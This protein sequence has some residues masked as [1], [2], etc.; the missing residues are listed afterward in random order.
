VNPEGPP[1]FVTVPEAR[2]SENRTESRFEVALSADGSATVRGTSRITGAQAPEYRRA[3]LSAHDRRSQLEKAF[4]RTFPG[5]R[6]ESV[7]LSDVTRIEEDVRMEFSLAVPRYAQADGSELR[8]NAFGAGSGYLETY[9]SLSERRHPLDLGE[10]TES[11]FEYRYSLPEGFTATE[12]PDDVSGEVPEVAFEVR[13][14]LDG[15][16][17]VVSGHVTFR[18]GRVAPERYPAFRALVARLDGAFT[19]RVR[20]APAHASLEAR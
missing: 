2:A 6:V 17:L 8:F 1:R 16:T 11:R 15:N 5:L 9:A 10:P 12:L 13:H 18:G 19:R 14:R 4:N 7:T 3:Y 20:I